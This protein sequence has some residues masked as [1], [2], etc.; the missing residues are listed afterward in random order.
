MFVA[1]AINNPKALSYSFVKIIKASL[2]IEFYFSRFPDYLT[3][4]QY[5]VTKITITYIST[6]TDKQNSCLISIL[7]K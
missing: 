3:S 2:K 4:A 7:K 5:G 1:R 6:K